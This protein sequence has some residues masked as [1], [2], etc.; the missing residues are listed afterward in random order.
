MN[1]HLGLRV[2][3]QS[4]ESLLNDQADAWDRLSGGVPFRRTMWLRP[5]WTHFGDSDRSCFLTVVD[6]DEQIRGLLPLERFGN[7]GWQTIGGFQCTDYVSLLCQESDRAAVADAIADFL[8]SRSKDP[9]VGW[10][11][12]HFEGVV[13]GDPAMACLIEKLEA[14]LGST[15]IESR[16]S[17]W[18]RACEDS[19]DQFLK[20]HSRKYRHRMRAMVR[21][22][23]STDDP[24][25]VNFPQDQSTVTA[26]LNELIRL[27]QAHWLSSG[28]TGSFAAEGMIEFIHE[29]ALSAL[30]EGRLFFPV[31]TRTNPITKAESIVAAQLH[32]IGD[33]GR[34]YCYTTG[35]NYEHGDLTPGKLL[36]AYILHHLHERNSAEGPVSFD[37][38]H[39]ADEAHPADEVHPINRD[40]LKGVDFLRGDEEYKQRIYAQSAPLL[41]VDAFAPTLRGRVACLGHDWLQSA[42]QRYRRLRKR[43]PCD[44]FSTSEAFDSGYLRF[45]PEHVDPAQHGIDS[46]HHG[47]PHPIDLIATEA[48]SGDEAS[49]IAL[50]SVTS[51]CDDLGLIDFDSFDHRLLSTDLGYRHT[52]R[53]LSSGDE[54]ESV[55]FGE[56]ANRPE[57]NEC[58][59]F[60]ETIDNALDDDG[61]VILSFGAHA[62][63]SDDGANV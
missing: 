51:S 32:F 42:K 49:T 40:R 45:L 50:A 47:L 13:A 5:L 43:P 17:V 29:S 38:R 41:T 9:D 1:T 44:T 3:V 24:I 35:V 31:M 36:N 11:R 20:N 26:C 58:P 4:P 48:L 56:F 55:E 52:S 18:Y 37:G 15:R 6:E 53:E 63:V 27:H 7:R 8:V 54:T 28:E 19:W 14:R 62:R 60:N 59:E 61:P 25:R 46:Q 16:M 33:D 39:P 2:L 23:E 12:L 10:D 34:L 30:R 22:F 21:Q 57:F